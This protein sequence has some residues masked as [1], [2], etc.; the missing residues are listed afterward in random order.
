M[1]MAF[2]LLCAAFSILVYTVPAAAQ[3]MS[4]WGTPEQQEALKKLQQAQ[5]KELSNLQP[6]TD[7]G[8]P[9]T[10]VVLTGTSKPVRPKIKTSKAKVEGVDLP[11]ISADG[12][13]A[14]ALIGSEM[15]FSG[16]TTFRFMLIDVAKDVVTAEETVAET[17]FGPEGDYVVKV[18]KGVVAKVNKVLADREWLAME[19]TTVRLPGC[20]AEEP[21]SAGCV[22]NAKVAGVDVVYREPKLTV[23]GTETE[24]GAWSTAGYCSYSESG[25]DPATI[26]NASE[27]DMWCGF[28]ASI[29]ALSYNHDKRTLLF[30]ID[31]LNPS[32]TCSSLPESSVH[33][34][35]LP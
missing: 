31:Y 12:S 11:A 7:E 5:Q 33:V 4:G 26:K 20:V 3:G 19:T 32:D 23:N 18:S 35:K 13:T 1:K 27:C 34:A 24:M 17:D 28:A 30:H 16:R 2:P 6:A 25:A 15:D 22:V 9:A 21:D 14:A 29:T 10:P 8:V